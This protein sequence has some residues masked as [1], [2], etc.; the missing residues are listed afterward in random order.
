MTN[1]RATKSTLSEKR[2]TW[3]IAING[4]DQHSIQRQL[5]RMTW[6]AAVFHVVNEARGMADPAS[7]GGVQL[8]GMFHQ[9][10]DQGFFISQSVAIRR[11]ADGYTLAGDRGVYSL[12]AVLDDMEE[13]RDLLTRRNIYD[14]EELEYDDTAIQQRF[15]DGLYHH[16]KTGEYPSNMPP[17]GLYLQSTERHK[18]IDQL[19]G[20]VAANRSPG[21]QIP[22]SVI[23]NLRQRVKAVCDDV[24]EHVN[25]YVAH[26]STPESRSD[27]EAS[28]SRITLQHLEDAR[29]ALCQVAMFVAVY[30]LGDSS[31]DFFPIPQ[32][33]QFKYIERPLVTKNNVAALHRLWD[34]RNSMAQKQHRWTIED[35]QRQFVD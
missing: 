10:F 2:Q 16:H 26:A 11:L 1:D 22:V 13:H 15:S 27:V 29:V 9:L 34:T 4:T 24:V 12:I 18:H 21:D 3:L 20:I 19:C 32:Y 5:V 23:R 30:I 6:D 28:G 33:D 35:Y 8:N 7:D 31:S 17:S 14:A 25:K